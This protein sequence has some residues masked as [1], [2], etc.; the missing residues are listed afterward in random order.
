MDIRDQV[1]D[2]EHIRLRRLCAADLEALERIL[3]DESMLCAGG[4]ERALEET[5]RFMNLYGECGLG[6]LA[7]ERISDGRFLG[8]VG[9][10]GYEVDGVRETALSWLLDRRFRGLGLATE[11]A[12]ALRDWGFGWGLPRVVSLLDPDDGASIDVARKIGMRYERDVPFFG[13]PR[14]LL[15]ASHP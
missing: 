5:R 7:V 1:L 8:R 12:R 13:R 15:F 9:Y 3:D 10:V 14:V 11:A 6:M 4:R 2:T